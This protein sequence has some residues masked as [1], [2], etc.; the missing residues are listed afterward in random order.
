MYT[1]EKA[2]TAGNVIM[3][4]IRKITSDVW[5]ARAEALKKTGKSLSA[6]DSK[7]QLSGS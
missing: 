5:Q 6:L 2:Q 4:Q 7:F 1:P 3:E